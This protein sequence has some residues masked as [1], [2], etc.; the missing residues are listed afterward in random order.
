MTLLN[1]ALTLLK[2]GWPFII[3]IGIVVAKLKWKAWVI[4]V[5]ILEKRGKNIVKTNDRAARYTDKFTKLT[6]Y[7]LLKLKDTIPVVEYNWILHN[8]NKHTNI[9]ERLVNVLRPTQGTLFLFKYGS[10]QYK[11]IIND[12]DLEAEKKLVATEDAEGNKVYVYQYQQFDPRGYLNAVKMEVFDWD[13]MNFAFQEMRASFER[14]QKEGQ[15]M[16]T[17]L[18]PIAI[19]ACATMV[20]IVMMK[21]SLDFS[22]IA[23]SKGPVGDVSLPNQPAETPN[24][25]FIGDAFAPK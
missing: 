13:N 10:K 16:K 11:P 12:I 15:W 1:D 6:G 22:S 18:M 8:N 4:D 3:L 7:R 5:V 17:I 24:I 2:F 14:R 25:P 20:S 9:L 23:G 21:M 19:I